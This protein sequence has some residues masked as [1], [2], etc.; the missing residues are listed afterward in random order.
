MKYYINS[1]GA[2]Q[3]LKALNPRKPLRTIKELAF[4]F[5]T[6]RQTL[7]A[8]MTHHNGPLP[9][10]MTKKVWYDP[11]EVRAWWKALQQ[12]KTKTKEAVKEQS[13]KIAKSTRA[14]LAQQW[15]R[16][17]GSATPTQMIAAGFLN[18]SHLTLM[19]M[20]AFGALTRDVRDGKIYYCATDIDYIT[21]KGFQRTPNE[22]N[23][24]SN[25]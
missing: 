15:I 2:E 24:A 6:T 13:L 11:D 17:Q 1:M 7:I 4:E 19:R 18:M 10:F 20:V 22:R 12:N 21:K 5:G 14:F 3:K 16:E 9:V 8:H 23:S 25:N